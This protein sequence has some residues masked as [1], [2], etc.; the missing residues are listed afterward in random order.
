[1]VF[2]KPAIM[3][4]SERFAFLL[5]ALFVGVLAV[6]IVRGSGSYS[7]RNTSI[8]LCVIAGAV[9]IWYFLFQRNA[10]NGRITV[11]SLLGLVAAL[12][13]GLNLGMLILKHFA[14]P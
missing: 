4:P 5:I 9:A 6:M 8:V 1:M 10:R 2:M 14:S 11:R 13:V 7:V 3:K 12:A